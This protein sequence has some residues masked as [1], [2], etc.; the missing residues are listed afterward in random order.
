MRRLV[1][2]SAVVEPDHCRQDQPALVLLLALRLLRW[3]VY[4]EDR[5]QA[6]SPM[7][8]ACFKTF[9]CSAFQKTNAKSDPCDVMKGAATLSVSNRKMLFC[10][11]TFSFDKASPSAFV[12]PQI[13]FSEKQS[14]PSGFFFKAS[15]IFHIFTKPV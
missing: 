13:P 6:S 8:R 7:R 15:V 4:T 11:D 12:S 14:Q 2:L 3:N 10:E 1:L 9:S 5:D